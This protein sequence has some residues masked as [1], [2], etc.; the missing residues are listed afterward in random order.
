MQFTDR[1]LRASTCPPITAPLPLIWGIVTGR[2]AGL[3]SR[4]DPASYAE[5]PITGANVTSPRTNGTSGSHCPRDRTK[6]I[7]ART[8]VSRPSTTVTTVSVLLPTVQSEVWPTHTNNPILAM[9]PKRAMV[10]VTCR[11][12]TATATN[13]SVPTPSD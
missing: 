7:V 13:A 5:Y 10:M 8:I 9:I 3:N 4:T 2:I 12:L 6:S 11:R 1:S